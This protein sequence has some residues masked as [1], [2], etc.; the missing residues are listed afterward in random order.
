MKR[1]FVILA[2]VAGLALPSAAAATTAPAPAA[3]TPCVTSDTGGNCGPYFDPQ[4]VNSSGY[5][6]YVENNAWGCGAPGSCGRQTLTSYGPA[7]WSV[8]S[9]QAAGNTG[10]LTYPNVAQILTATTNVDPPIA[11]FKYLHSAFAESMPGPGTGTDA[12]AGY[13]IWTSGGPRSQTGEVMIW[14]QNVNRGTGGSKVLLNH[15]FNRQTFTLMQYG[16][17]RGELI[18][19]LRHNETSGTVHIKA[20]LKWL[21]NHGYLAAHARI[22]QV[23][24]GWEICSTGGHPRQFSVTRYNLLA[25][26][27]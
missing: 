8:T 24:F 13:D 25:K 26:R 27:Q 16:G 4:M 5:N 12:E 2:A 3:A 7:H 23:D 21:M 6:T 11:S 17:Y 1:L 22:A 18:W 15:T 20:M 14:T 9:S 19:W 10:V